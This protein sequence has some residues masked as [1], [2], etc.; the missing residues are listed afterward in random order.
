VDYIVRSV[1]AL[2]RRDFK[3]IDGLADA[4]RVR[5]RRTRVSASSTAKVVEKTYETHRVQILDPACGTGTFLYAILANIRE[6]FKGNAG[7]WPG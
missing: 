4:S 5:A 7:M 6:R 1:D 2:L 3:L